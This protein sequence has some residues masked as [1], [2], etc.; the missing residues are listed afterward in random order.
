MVG[1][2]ENT[3]KELLDMYESASE[4]YA[5]T[6]MRIDLSNGKILY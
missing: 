5:G 2:H 6:I 1:N 3:L 4:M